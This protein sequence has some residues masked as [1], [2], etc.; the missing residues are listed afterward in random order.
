MHEPRKLEWP[1]ETEQLLSTYLDGEG[2]IRNG[3]FI[4][5][6]DE[7]VILKVRRRDS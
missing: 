1:G 5:R 6:A 2:T 4:L 3:P 7:G